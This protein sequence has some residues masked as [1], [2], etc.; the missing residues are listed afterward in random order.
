[1]GRGFEPP[2]GEDQSQEGGAQ[3]GQSQEEMMGQIGDQTESPR[4]YKDGGA[5]N[6]RR[7]RGGLPR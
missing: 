3:K 2:G 5:E 4:G 1:M 7:Q 6:E